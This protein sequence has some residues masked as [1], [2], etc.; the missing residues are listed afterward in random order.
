MVKNPAANAR[1][2]RGVGSIPEL[3]RSPA[4]GYGNTLQHSCVENSL[5]RGACRA[6]VHGVAKSRTRLK[7]LS[8]CKGPDSWSR[9]TADVSSGAG[10]TNSLVK[11][12][13]WPGPLV[14]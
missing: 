1:G 3:G 13:T 6:A 8:T 4:E 14:Q 7:Q 10:S 2:R 12:W 11:W 9:L 5:D